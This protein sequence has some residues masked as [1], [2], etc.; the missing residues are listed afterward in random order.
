MDLGVYFQVITA[1]GVI[2]ALINYVI[3]SRR[4]E[5]T[6][7]IALETRQAQL[8]MTFY[9]HV[10]KKE[11]WGT[12]VRVMWHYNFTTIQEWDE[13]WGPIDHPEEA[14]ELYTVMQ[15][16]EGAGVLLKEDTIKREILFSYLPTLTTIVSW[17]K[18]KPIILGLRERY[19]DP[20]FGEMFEYL[21]NEAKRYRPGMRNPRS[22]GTRE[23]TLLYPPNPRNDE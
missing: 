7:R 9:T 6:Q 19:N 5:Q 14:T 18:F 16:F 8:A 10:T 23:P 3:T 4:S 22:L 1:V 13:N 20:T 2:A 15:M 17:T 21:F 11:F 12:W